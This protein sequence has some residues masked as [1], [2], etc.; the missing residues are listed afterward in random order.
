MSSVE[1]TRASFRNVFLTMLGMLL[2][3]ISL[4]ATIP[5][6]YSNVD[7]KPNWLIHVILASGLFVV[8]RVILFYVENLKRSVVALESLIF[9]AY[10]SAL[11]FRFS[12]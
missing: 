1:S 7:D 2:F 9:I 6:V 8:S 11:A 3:A 10:A 12:M 5:P 4:F